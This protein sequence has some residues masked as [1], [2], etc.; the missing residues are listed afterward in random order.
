MTGMQPGAIGPS[1]V[2]DIEGVDGQPYVPHR[3]DYVNADGEFKFKVSGY[4]GLPAIYLRHAG[5]GRKTNRKQ[6]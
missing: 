5:S 4:V 3:P 1:T 6:I 2:F